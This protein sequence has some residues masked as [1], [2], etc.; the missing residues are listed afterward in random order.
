MKEM[1]LQTKD[2]EKRRFFAL[3]DR[4]S[5]SQDSFERNR[6]KMELARMTF[7]E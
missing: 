4:L 5:R 3:A 6:I 7:G 2:A 1:S